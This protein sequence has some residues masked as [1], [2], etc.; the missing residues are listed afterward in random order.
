MAALALLIVVPG[1]LVF[2][3]FPVLVVA[4]VLCGVP[5]LAKAWQ[6]LA[7]PVSDSDAGAPLPVAG[8][9]RVCG[10]P[11]VNERSTFCEEHRWKGPS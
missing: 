7:A 11:A 6:W 10:R 3:M 2:G 1:F 4:G 9:C 5:L 8:T